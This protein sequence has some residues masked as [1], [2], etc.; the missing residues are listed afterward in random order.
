MICGLLDDVLVVR[1]QPYLCSL[2]YDVLV[3]RMQTDLWF[4]VLGI[5]GEDTD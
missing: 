5:G 1:V 4:N 2:L 3:V